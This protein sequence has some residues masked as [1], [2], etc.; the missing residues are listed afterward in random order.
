MARAV[1]RRDWDLALLLHRSHPLCR[2]HLL[3]DQRA[4]TL[5]LADPAAFTQLSNE[6]HWAVAQSAERKLQAENGA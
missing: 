2:E 1:F 6:L 5:S 3:L 4:R